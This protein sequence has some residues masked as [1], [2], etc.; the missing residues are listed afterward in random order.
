MNVNEP[1]EYL[2]TPSDEGDRDTDED[3]EVKMS[4]SQT[5]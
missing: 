3:S 4:F 1:V 5:I 2:E